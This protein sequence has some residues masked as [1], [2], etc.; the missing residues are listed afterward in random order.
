MKL[1]GLNA[2]AI[3]VVLVLMTLEGVTPAQY[4]L[5]HVVTAEGVDYGRVNWLHN[6]GNED[7][8]F[9]DVNCAVFSSINPWN[10]GLNPLSITPYPGKE[11]DI[12]LTNQGMNFV[13]TITYP[14]NLDKTCPAVLLLPG[15][16]GERD[17]LPVS[18]TYVIPEG[19][20][21]Q[22]MWERAALKLAEAGY[23][24]L[25]IDYRC[26]GKSEGYWQDVTLTGE[27]SDVDVAIRYLADNPAVDKDRIAVVGYSLGGALAACSTRSPLVKVVAL[28]SAAPDPATIE[29]ILSEEQRAELEEKGIITM[30]LPWGESTTL[31]KAFFDSC[32]ELDPVGDIAKF[33]GPLLVFCCLKDTMV[34]PQP[35]MSMIFMDAHRGPENLV[36]LNADH[37][38]N[39]FSGPNELDI[40]IFQTMEWLDRWL[41]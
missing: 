17:G 20:R 23:I 5:D 26:S 16:M 18:G 28:W 33:D 30:T 41:R 3:F 11:L 10:V 19:G 22:G 24:S 34:A 9:T 36:R 4:E 6:R 39:I 13:G 14:R 29:T 2:G 7:D 12:V 15:F 40:A 38:Y 35:E 32:K 8:V 25:R 21:P 27:L 1:N 37:S 31:K